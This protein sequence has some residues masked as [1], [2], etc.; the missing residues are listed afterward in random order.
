MR[1]IPVLLLISGLGTLAAC[2]R[3]TAV[4]IANNDS[5][6]L[7]TAIRQ[8]NE[9]P[10]PDTIRLA[11]NGLYILGTPAQPGL[12]LPPIEGQLTIEGN[13]AEV[14][15]YS[16]KPAAI[17]EVAQDAR[18]RIADLVL[19]EGNDGAVRNYGE[20]RLENVA[21]V[22]SSVATMPAIVLNHGRIE[23]VDSE[24]AY[25]LLLANRRDAGTVLNYGE[26]ELERSRIHDN[27]TVGRQRTL[28]AAGGI[29]NFGSVKA[30]GLVIHD[31]ELPAEDAPLLSF[32]GILN[33]GNGRV[34]GTTPAEAVRDAR[35]PAMF[36][37]F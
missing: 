14:R 4:D 36:A 12:L 27:R 17:L 18:L 23:A 9:N 16:D 20:L 1:T 32:G 10:G 19:A 15:G 2:T 13:H 31:N 34:S 22:D 33:I 28:A 7:V 5:A 3:E 21:I 35:Q 26:L 29:L 30:D 37:G 6:A 11:R 25:N 24:I 8:A